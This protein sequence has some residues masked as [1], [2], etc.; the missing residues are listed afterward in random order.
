[1]TDVITN[2][3]TAAIL[4]LKG[5]HGTSRTAAQE[6]VQHQIF[7]KTGKGRVGTGVYFWRENIYAKELASCWYEYRVRKGY[8]KPNE[9]AVIY[10][11]IAVNKNDF[12]DLEK[13]LYKD[14]LGIFAMQQPSLEHLDDDAGDMGALYNVFI[15]R[16]EKNFNLKCRVFQ[17]RIPSPPKCQTYPTSLLGNPLAYVV[18]D[19]TCIHLDKIEEIRK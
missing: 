19:E 13:P 9:G 6:I 7:Q 10:A 1:M 3:E 18:R 14:A 16:L 17:I 4:T 12:L 2:I 8:F 15:E 11:D 5:V